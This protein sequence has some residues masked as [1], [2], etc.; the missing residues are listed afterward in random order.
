MAS[1]D[2]AQDEEMDDPINDD[3]L[4]LILLRNLRNATHTFGEGTPPTESIRTT[5]E[6]HLQD[7][8]RRGVTTNLAKAKAGAS[9]SQDT[10]KPEDYAQLVDVFAKL[11]IRSKER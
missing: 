10:E 7:M 5:I 9:T 8:K 3:E 11:A 4:L 2:Q 1:Q 6:D